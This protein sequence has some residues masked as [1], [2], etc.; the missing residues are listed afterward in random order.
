ML[1]NVILLVSVEDIRINN[2]FYNY[3]LAEEPLKAVSTVRDLG[4]QLDSK[5]NFCAHFDYVNNQ[6]FKMLGF[7]IRTSRCLHNINSIRLIYISLVRSVLEYC[8]VVWS[9]T[10]EVHIEKLEKVQN[11]FIR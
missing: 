3:K 11:K 6:A 5:L 7:I 8:S 1:E 4:V 9:P 2:P 10:Y